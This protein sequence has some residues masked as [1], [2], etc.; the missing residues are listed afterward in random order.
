MV[1]DILELLHKVE[2]LDLHFFV[3][4]P[5][6]PN[7]QVSTSPNRPSP[8]GL[9]RCE[10]QFGH[11]QKDECDSSL[12]GLFR[13]LSLFPS[14]DEL[15]IWDGACKFGTSPPLDLPV[16]LRP[17]IEVKSVSFRE[18][19]ERDLESLGGTLRLVD[20]LRA[21]TQP[22]TLSALEV[23]CSSAEE[24]AA[25]G[26]LI[27]HARGALT[28]LDV[29]AEALLPP[30]DGPKEWQDPLDDHWQ[31][32]NLELCPKLDT[33]Q[34]H[35]HFRDDPTDR[36]PR[37]PQ[38]DQNSE[39]DDDMSQC[40]NEDVSQLKDRDMSRLEDEDVPQPADGDVLQPSRAAIGMLSQ[41]SSSVR[42]IT[43][44]L[45]DLPPALSATMEMIKQGRLLG[46]QAFDEAITK[47]MFP[48]VSKVHLHVHFQPSIGN[49][50]MSELREIHRLVW[51][52]ML[53]KL[54]TAEVLDFGFKVREQPYSY[55]I[56]GIR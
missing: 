30:K 40:E 25:V 44:R 47:K 4:V 29:G 46:L 37:R 17:P 19:R 7:A 10:I 9:K 28:S 32:L 6:A 33:L 36:A 45:H 26:E 24:V 49:R 52:H 51:V 31:K 43:I 18:C 50:Y 56:P 11:W 39:G 38:Q 48:R 12:P 34:M 42:D 15:R 21:I 16:L 2:Y 1:S 23:R 14:I 22:G 3:Y 5:S 41:V 27:A 54:D 55:F 35:I 53:P 13:I 8:R 20:A